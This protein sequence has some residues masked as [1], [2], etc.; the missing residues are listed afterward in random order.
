M[1]YVYEYTYVVAVIQTTRIPLRHGSLLYTV[2][3]SNLYKDYVILA[4]VIYVQLKAAVSRNAFM[5]FGIL[6]QS[7]RSALSV[8]LE[9]SAILNG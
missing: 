4:L 6:K 2:Q 7:K 1:V 8:D 9:F 5:V 3:L